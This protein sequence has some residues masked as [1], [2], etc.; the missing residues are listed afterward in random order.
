VKTLSIRLDDNLGKAF[1]ESCQRTGLKKNTLVARLIASFVRH[2][3]ALLKGKKGMKDPFEEV[4]GLMK[5]EPFL[6]ASES[7]DKA[8]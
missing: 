7:V 3:K 8:V 4:I 2:Q 5:I 1:D 6:D